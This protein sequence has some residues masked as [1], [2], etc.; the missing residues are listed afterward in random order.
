[1][2]DA[3]KNELVSVLHDAFKGSWE[4]GGGTEFRYKH[5]IEVAEFSIKIVNV[6]NLEVD[7]DALYV[8]GLF[9]DIGKVYAIND[10][11][12]IDYESEANK[13]HENISI[14]DLKK[15]TSDI[16]SDELTERAV[17]II[18]EELN[19][20][21]SLERR[22]LKDADE[23]GN[24]GYSQVWRTFNFIA[25]T[26]QTYAQMLEFWESGNMEDRKK[27]I[28]QLYF[29]ISKKVAKERYERF[30]DFI[31]VIQEESSGEDIS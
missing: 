7:V 4:L 28:D 11:G 19:E 22:V 31:K 6:E 24:F 25:L 27:W 10:N 16:I 2:E 23:L 29:N 8:A 14:D 30:A 18:R 9:H 1:M 15:H 17:G 12:E 3:I 20:N 5:G 26:K 21:S 13:N